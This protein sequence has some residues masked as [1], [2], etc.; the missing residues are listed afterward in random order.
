MQA[1][2]IGQLFGVG[3]VIGVVLLLIRQKL[4]CLGGVMEEF[5][6]SSIKQLADGNLEEGCKTKF[7]DNKPIFVGR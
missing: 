7:L 3:L 1:L 2:N 4:N 5:S 6:A